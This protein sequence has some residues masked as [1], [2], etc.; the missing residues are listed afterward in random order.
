M[1][2]QRVLSAIV[3]VPVV[4]G[5]TYFGGWVFFTLVFIVTLLAGYEFFALL[6]SRGYHPAPVLGL[7]LIAGLIIAASLPD[8]HL[9][10]LVLA[11]GLILSLLW[12]I[13]RS[14]LRRSLSDW[15]LTMTGAV[16]I[17]WLAGFMISV[18]ELPDGL[19][20]ILVILVG[21]WANDSAAYLTGVY[22]AGRYLGRH[23]FAP[24]VSPKK[25]WEGSVAG[26]LMCTAVT[27]GLAT[28]LGAPLPSSIGIGLAVGIL[29]TMGDLGV[30]VIKRQVGV[31]DS[32]SLI[33][34]HGGMLDRVDSLLFASVIVYYF[35]LWFVQPR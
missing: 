29:G 19:G 24:T 3:L 34:G 31:K 13:G 17:G 23:A 21:T 32:S 20:W 33:P 10:R 9:D 16:Y 8:R 11:V 35:V 2:Q 14:P 1:L 30:S 18:R 28:F 4:L 26:W 27:A 5:A 7:A 6:A 15:A 22:L 12:Q 25:T